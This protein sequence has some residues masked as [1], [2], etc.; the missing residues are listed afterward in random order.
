M[1]SAHSLCKNSRAWISKRDLFMTPRQSKKAMSTMGS[2]GI[3][4][5]S[6]LLRT[7][8]DLLW[9]PPGQLKGFPCHFSGKEPTCQCRRH[10]RHG[11]NPRVRKIHWRRKQQPILVFLPGESHGQRSPEGRKESIMTETT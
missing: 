6:L 5:C 9:I 7:I 1:K 2:A 10:K 8:G 11:C 4:S 3:C